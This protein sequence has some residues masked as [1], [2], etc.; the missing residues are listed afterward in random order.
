MNT[1][2]ELGKI[3]SDLVTG[4]TG[5]ASGVATYLT[6]CNQYL[7]QPQ[8]KEDDNSRYPESQWIDEGRLVVIGNW[9]EKDDVKAD[10]NGCDREAPK[11]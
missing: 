9:V 1:E 3:V 10:L 5:V 11:K 2:I 8:C 7:V 4:F 6:G